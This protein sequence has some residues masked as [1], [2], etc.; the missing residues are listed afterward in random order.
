MMLLCLNHCWQVFV[1]LR[2]CTDSSCMEHL[3]R[4]NKQQQCVMRSHLLHQVQ[5]CAPACAQGT[6][7][8]IWRDWEMTATG[9]LKKKKNQ[10]R[11]PPLHIS[12]LQTHCE[13]N[14]DWSVQICE[15][16]GQGT[17]TFTFWT[18]R[19]FASIRTIFAYRTLGPKKTPKNKTKQ[20][21]KTLKMGYTKKTPPV[22]VTF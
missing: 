18:A 7:K 14:W 11:K 9:K 8:C 13:L 10:P 19:I 20:T 4:E 3:I 1:S 6:F 17:I 2:A 15:Q 12:P 21:K 22:E 5:E 16:R